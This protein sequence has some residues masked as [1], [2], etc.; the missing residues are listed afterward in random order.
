[1]FGASDILK[2]IK[3]NQFYEA[4]IVGRS[5]INNY[6]GKESTQIVID[7]VEFKTCEKI[8]EETNNDGIKSLEELI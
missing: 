8:A 2:T 7:G 4:T 5:Q 3:P 6:M 1:M